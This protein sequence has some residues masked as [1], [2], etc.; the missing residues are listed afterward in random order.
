VVVMAAVL[1]SRCFVVMLLIFSSLQGKKL[2]STPNNNKH[3][4]EQHSMDAMC[5][6]LLFIVVLC[7][8]VWC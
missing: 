7:V 3:N 8:V 5:S 1:C 2:N 4:N 6:W